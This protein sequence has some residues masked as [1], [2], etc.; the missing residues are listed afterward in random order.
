MQ[1]LLETQVFTST[2]DLLVTNEQTKCPPASRP[3]PLLRSSAMWLTSCPPHCAPGAAGRGASSTEMS[4]MSATNCKSRD[5]PW[6]EISR[7][8]PERKLRSREAP[9]LPP[10][11]GLAAPGPGGTGAWRGDGGQRGART[12]DAAPTPEGSSSPHLPGA[13]GRGEDPGTGLVRGFMSAP[14]ALGNVVM[15][16]GGRLH[17][18]LRLCPVLSTTLFSETGCSGEVL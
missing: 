2:G 17:S 18:R 12:G 8:Q 14:N 13:H 3:S 16:A 7:L 4:K 9:V 6:W 11:E 5:T 15:S 1:G 10:G